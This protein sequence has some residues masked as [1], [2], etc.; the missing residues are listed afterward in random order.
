MPRDPVDLFI[1]Q[2]NRE[3]PDLDPAALGMVSRI[4]MLAK[5]LEQSAD[6][7]L[8]ASNLSLWQFDVLAALRRSGAP[9]KLS[10][11]QLMRSVTLTSGAMTNRIDRL[12]ELGLVARENDPDDRRGTLIALTRQGRKVV[13][14]AIEARLVDARANV[15]ELSSAEQKTLAALLRRLLVANG[16]GAGRNERASRGAVGST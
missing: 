9:F 5:M 1:A 4:L 14:T 10:P 12:E 8:A 2:W 15:A 16:P 6:R 11:T 7:A 3:R 13:D